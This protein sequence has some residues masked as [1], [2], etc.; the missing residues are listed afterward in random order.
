MLKNFFLILFKWDNFKYD[1]EPLKIEVGGWYLARIFI[2]MYS[3]ILL[4]K[5]EKKSVFFLKLSNVYIIQIIY[6]FHK[7]HMVVVPNLS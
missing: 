1:E 2:L 6:G 5:N 4:Y 3:A 7:H